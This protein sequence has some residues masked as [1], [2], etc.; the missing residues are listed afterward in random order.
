MG[1]P[2]IFRDRA[3]SRSARIVTV[4]SRAADLATL[5]RLTD[6]GSLRPVVDRVY[7]LDQVIDAQRYL[8]TKRARGKIVML[9]QE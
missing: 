2:R 7:P 9:I 5:R 4:R 3:S 1:V 8:E 6:E